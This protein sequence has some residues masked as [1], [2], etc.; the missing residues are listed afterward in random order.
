MYDFS[1]QPPIVYFHSVAPYKSPSWIRSYLTLEL[2]YFEDLL[3][4]IQRKK[5]KTFFISK[6]NNAEFQKDNSI[7]LSFDDGY[8]DN[9]VYVFPL[10]KRYNIKA[11]IFCSLDYIDR[12]K[13]VRPTI[14]NV[15]NRDISES[16]LDSLGFCSIEELKVMEASGFVDIQSHTITHVKYPVSDKITGFHHPGNKNVNFYFW[17]NPGGMSNLI[18]QINFNDIVVPYGFPLF[19][20]KSAVVSARVWLNTEFN[21]TIVKELK[22]TDWNNY[23][24]NG[25][26]HKIK[27]IINDFQVKDKIIIKREAD[28]EYKKRV[29]K[30]VFQ[31]KQKL[32]QL[33]NKKISVICWPHGDFNKLSVD[34]ARE[35][36]YNRIHF[37][38][39][40][41]NGV[42]P[43][44]DHFVRIGMGV[45][46]N[47]RFLTNQKIRFCINI[48]RKKF[49]Y[50]FLRSIY[51]SFI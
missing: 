28:T 13:T 27:P 32:E 42:I 24:F 12:K 22:D 9:Y 7:G 14:E 18:N 43:E 31:S 44:K 15:W 50:P 51:K 35:A 39:T 30:E 1:D 49:P 37:V 8:L 41:N 26:L 23:N 21:D 4:Y 47:N 36:G 45:V 6:L 34:L 25:L 19:E 11:T 16:E 20:E 40:K 10:L 38:E 3:K 5:Y 29:R 17:G 2:V 33:L 48:A 46:K